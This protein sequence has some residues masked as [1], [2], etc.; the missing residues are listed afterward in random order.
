MDRLVIQV[1]IE[2]GSVKEVHFASC[3]IRQAAAV[4][5]HFN[6]VLGLKVNESFSGIDL[7]HM[8]HH[9]G[10]LGNAL[11]YSKYNVLAK[12]L[13]LHILQRQK[14]V[15]I[16]LCLVP[17]LEFVCRGQLPR[18]AAPQRA[19]VVKVTTALQSFLCGVQQLPVLTHATCFLALLQVRSTA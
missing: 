11:H 10:V 7:N 3:E 17:G 19:V 6:I 12:F 8:F 2:L 15:F 18:A 16:W 5:H 9:N 13:F 1:D 14:P 4:S